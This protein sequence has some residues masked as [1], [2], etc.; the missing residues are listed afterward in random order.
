MDFD[1]GQCGLTVCCLEISWVVLVLDLRWK[2]S[3]GQSFAPCIRKGRQN[4]FPFLE[5]NSSFLL[6]FLRRLEAFVCFIFCI[7]DCYAVVL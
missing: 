6:R 7:S 4:E 5:V 3:V 2:F 1:P